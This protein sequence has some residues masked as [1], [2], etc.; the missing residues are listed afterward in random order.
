MPACWVTACYRHVPSTCPSFGLL[1][2][3]AQS[4]THTL[5]A[6]NVLFHVP[7]NVVSCCLPELQAVHQAGPHARA[8]W[9]HQAASVH[10]R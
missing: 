1:L 6:F 2:P 3:C 4:E 5:P 9:R 10:R 7:A 8:V